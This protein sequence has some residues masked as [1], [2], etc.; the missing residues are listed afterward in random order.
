MR[1]HWKCRRSC[2]PRDPICIVHLSRRFFW[3]SHATP[4]TSSST[5]GIKRHPWCDSWSFTSASARANN[6]AWAHLCISFKNM[7][8]AWML[9]TCF[10]WR[11]SPSSWLIVCGRDG[12]VLAVPPVS[13]CSLWR[14]ILDLAF[15]V[16]DKSTVPGSM[17]T[18]PFL[19]RWLGIDTSDYI[20]AEKLLVGGFV[21]FKVEIWNQKPCR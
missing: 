8:H 10:K 5:D 3:A 16:S 9:T 2:L 15:V 18:Y 19:Q 1:L 13:A 21:M 12:I 17:L 7:P 4:F 14:T 11:V 6:C 20:S